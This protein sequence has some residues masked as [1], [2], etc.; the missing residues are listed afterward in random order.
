MPKK[1][2]LLAFLLAA[3]TGFT[4]ATSA[5]I[6]VKFRDGDT[7]FNSDPAFQAALKDLGIT[8]D[9]MR[10]MFTRPAAE[11]DAERMEGERRSG[12]KLAN[13]DLYY[14]I[15]LPSDVSAADAMAK[16]QALNV[17]EHAELQ[18]MPAP[19]PMGR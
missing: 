2:F 8:T 6:A 7:A 11:L 9:H 17:V 5:Q 4:E 19:P 16:L 3:L 15:D 13:L 18:P 1:L 12:K 14:I 10:R